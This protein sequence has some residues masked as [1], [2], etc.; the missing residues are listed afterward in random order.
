MAKALARALKS[1]GKIDSSFALFHQKENMLFLPHWAWNDELLLKPSSFLKLLKA[2][3]KADVIFYHHVF[4]F[5][6]LV[7]LFFLRL[8]CTTAVV[9]IFHTHTDGAGGVLHQFYYSIRKKALAWGWALGANHLSFITPA[10]QNSFLASCYP[11][12][13]ILLKKAFV[14]GNFI[15]DPWLSTP[16][17]KRLA[18][19]PLEVLFVGRLTHFKGFD[20]YL[21]LS[22][23]LSPLG[24]RFHAAGTGLLA[25]QCQSHGVEHHGELDEKALLELYDLA[26]VFMLP[27]LTEVFPV[28]LLEALSRGCVPLLSRLAGLPD[29]AREKKEA[30]Y[31]RAKN[32]AEMEEQLLNLAQDLALLQSLSQQGPERAKAYSAKDTAQLYLKILNTEL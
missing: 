27:S 11:F 20:D 15:E 22:K 31:F 25:K 30:L 13:N 2:A 18:P 12:K 26:H 16:Q 28:V 19:M 8:F 3:K 4:D 1:H 6:C 17:K 24:F 32:R 9:G 10:V 29:I 7:H 23:K 14:A 21:A 5:S